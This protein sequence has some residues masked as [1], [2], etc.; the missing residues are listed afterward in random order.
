MGKG[1]PPPTL[2]KVQQKDSDFNK[3]RYLVDD[4][5]TLV[6]RWMDNGL[7]LVVST[8]HP[9]GKCVLVNRRRP[10][11]TVKNKAHVKQVWGNQY[12][13]DIYIPALIRHYNQWMGGVDLVDQHISYYMPKFHCQRNWIPM[14]IQMLAMICNNC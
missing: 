5:G 8:M 7:V 14:F 2:R 9:V 3:F 10:R 11:I 1:W 13:T 6:V 12:R 4:Y